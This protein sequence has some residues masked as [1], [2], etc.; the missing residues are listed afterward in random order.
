MGIKP[1]SL[2]RRA[3]RA[4]YFFTTLLGV[5]R[6]RVEGSRASLLARGRRFVASAA[7]RAD[8]GRE[9]RSPHADALTLPLNPPPT[10]P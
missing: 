1:E 4:A 8:A 5:S 9:G 10:N 6:T 7:A 3:A 2:T